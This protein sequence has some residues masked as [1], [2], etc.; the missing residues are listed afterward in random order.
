MRSKD[1]KIAV[2]QL[3]R[4]W[5]S[6]LILPLPFEE[7]Q[8][9]VQGIVANLPFPMN[10]H[11]IPIPSKRSSGDVGSKIT[12]SR[13]S[14]QDGIFYLDLTTQKRR[15]RQPSTPWEWGAATVLSAKN[16]VLLADLFSVP[17]SDVVAPQSAATAKSFTLPIHPA[18]FN[19]YK[20]LTPKS[21]DATGSLCWW[22][23]WIGDYRRGWRASIFWNQHRMLTDCPTNHILAQSLLDRILGTFSWVYFRQR[24]V[25]PLHYTYVPARE[26]HSPNCK[27]NEQ[28]W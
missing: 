5:L 24:W 25:C 28:R 4:V 2:V 17:T 9:D 22:H 11:S 6:A 23:D 21:A 10:S 19:T 27:G 3:P 20:R 7:C 8:S 12:E 26:W 14:R 13:F 1:A 18:R 15:T 16:M